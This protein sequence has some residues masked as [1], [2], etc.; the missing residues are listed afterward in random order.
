[1]PGAAVVSGPARM[2]CCDRKKDNLMKTLMGFLCFLLALL[3]FPFQS[4][5]AQDANIETV[6]GENVRASDL[7]LPTSA[8]LVGPASLASPQDGA[9]IPCVMANQYNNGFLF[10]FSGGGKKL[11]AMALDVRSQSFVIGQSYPVELAIGDGFDKIL[12]AEA[13]DPATLLVNLQDQPDIY[14]SLSGTGTMRFDVGGNHWEFA[15]LGTRDG[16]KRLE[17]CYGAP[18]VLD[19][20]ADQITAPI[21]EA[22]APEGTGDVDPSYRLALDEPPATPRPAPAPAGAPVP[23]VG[24]HTLSNPVPALEKPKDQGGAQVYL[25][26]Q[27][28]ENSADAAKKEEGG[29]G[30]LID[31]LLKSAERG[32][33]AERSANRDGLA[34]QQNRDVAPPPRSFAMDASEETENLS[35]LAPPADGGWQAAQGDDLRSILTQWSRRKDVVLTWRASDE[36]KVRNGIDQS[37][38]YESAVRSILEQ[39]NGQ[40]ERPVGRIYKDSASGKNVLVIDT[41]R[42][43]RGTN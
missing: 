41:D 3:A 42:S 11:L 31:R 12:T 34:P 37:G 19:A 14:D 25:K 18:V 26:G 27:A 2:S 13:F 33:G 10:R 36:F 22:S 8:W 29:S 7:F 23:A 32:I 4:C 30:G 20:Q 28:P 21:R 5:R 9:K 39:Y 16:L 15:L 1:M 6:A 38:D 43:R 40:D 17:A 24:M 35:R